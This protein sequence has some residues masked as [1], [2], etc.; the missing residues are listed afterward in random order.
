MT[1]FYLLNTVITIAGIAGGCLFLG[2]CPGNR[3]L[4]DRTKT[5]KDP[6]LV[7]YMFCLIIPPLLI[8]FFTPRFFIYQAFSEPL[9]LDLHVDKL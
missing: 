3:L 7:L 6:Y 9:T 2:L 1:F 4:R 5:D 8:L